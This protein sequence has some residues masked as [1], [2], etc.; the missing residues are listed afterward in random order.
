MMSHE[1]SKLL[2]SMMPL[3]LSGYR[4]LYGTLNNLLQKL[5]SIRTVH[6]LDDT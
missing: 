3:F 1:L 2:P 6:R 5:R 4:F